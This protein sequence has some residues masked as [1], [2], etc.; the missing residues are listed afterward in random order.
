MS[1]IQ[2]RRQDLVNYLNTVADS[3][4][5]L[6]RTLRTAAAQTQTAADPLAEF[7]CGLMALED[8]MRDRSLS[9]AVPLMW[10]YAEELRRFRV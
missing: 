3:S 5:S 8:F 10:S 1:G 6:A 4:E 9:R 2:H 7:A